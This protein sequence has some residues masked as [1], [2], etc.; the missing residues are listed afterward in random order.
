MIGR[1]TA[2]LGSV[3]GG[4]LVA[5]ALSAFAP[6]YA[7]GTVSGPDP[8]QRGSL[9]ELT[10]NGRDPLDLPEGKRA[11]L[12]D[13]DVVTLSAWAPGTGGTRVGLGEVTGRVVAR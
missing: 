1:R 13:G 7:S 12:E 2:T 11:F 6:A 8:D 9:L 10:W 4:T 5:A 3:L